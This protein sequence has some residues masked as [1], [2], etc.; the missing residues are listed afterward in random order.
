MTEKSEEDRGAVDVLLI[1]FKYCCA[2]KHNSDLLN[3]IGWIQ[4]FTGSVGENRKKLERSDEKATTD[5]F[6]DSDIQAERAP[7]SHFA[8]ETR[9]YSIFG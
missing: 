7:C 9:T 3:D 5:V 8:T 6:L 2:L 4:N 1:L